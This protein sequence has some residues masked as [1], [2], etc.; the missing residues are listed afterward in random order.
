MNRHTVF[1]QEGKMSEEKTVDTEFKALLDES[2]GKKIGWHKIDYNWR[3]VILYNL[4]VGAGFDE[5]TDEINYYFE[6]N[7]KVIPTFGTLVLFTAVNNI[8]PIPQPD[9]GFYILRHAMER[10]YNSYIRCFDFDHEIIFHRPID[11]YKGTLVYDSILDCYNSREKGKGTVVTTKSPVY[12]EAGL[13]LCENISTVLIRDYDGCGAEPYIATHVKFP[14]REPDIVKYGEFSRV[15]N[16]LYRLTGD[17]N[18][19]HIDPEWSQ[20]SNGSKPYMMGFCPQGFACRM[21]INAVCPDHPEKVKRFKNQFRSVSFPGDKFKFEGWIV[22]D[23]LM[24][25]R[26]VNTETGKP[27]LDKGEFEWEA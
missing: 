12:N 17:T 23:G 15:Q 4:A 1:Y 6:K 16:A 5:D 3:D 22:K 26:L 11:A 20:R 9:S 21:A 2:M 18:Y 8:P 19:V 24:W 27:I 10:H 25:F 7:L 14:E 13:L